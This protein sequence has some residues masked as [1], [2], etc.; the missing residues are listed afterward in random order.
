MTQGEKLSFVYSSSGAGGGFG[1][2]DIS[3][4]VA[5]YKADV[6]K[7]T[8]KIL[9]HKGGG[10]LGGKIRS[11][12]KYSFSVRAIREGYWELVIDKPL[13]E[14]EYAF[15]TVPVGTA[16]MDGSVTMFAFGVDGK[17]E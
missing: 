7:G 8:R 10:Y 14:G 16:G 12:D 5:L 1:M 2:M 15:T 17:N 6:G 13:P 9:L 11:S 4:M 3:S